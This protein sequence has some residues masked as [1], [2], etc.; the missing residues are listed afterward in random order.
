MNKVGQ[1]VLNPSGYLK[2]PVL[3]IIR[4]F[5]YRSPLV[6]V[7][8]DALDRSSDPSKRGIKT[9]YLKLRHYLFFEG[10]LCD[11]RI[12]RQ[13]SWSLSALGPSPVSGQFSGLSIP[14][15]G[16]SYLLAS[17]TFVTRTQ[18][19]YTYQAILVNTG[20]ALT[21]VTATATSL[22]P[23][24]TVVAGQGTLY[25]SSVPANGQAIST[26]TF[27]I[28]DKRRRSIRRVP[29]QLVIQWPIC[30]PRLESDRSRAQ[31]RDAERRG[32]DESQRYRLAD[33]QLGYSIGPGRLDRHT[34]ERKQRD[35]N[36]RCRICSELTSSLSL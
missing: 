22:S 34:V 32:F 1:C 10:F 12:S 33:L 13:L 17:Q 15:T 8:W 9:Q 11:I 5:L 35:S 19:Y 36:L 6:R 29:D 20:P 31:H 21:S 30:Q 3:T 26:N 2:V 24:V 4:R 16:S 14:P 7:Y 25:F 23:N 18:S 28:S 27:T